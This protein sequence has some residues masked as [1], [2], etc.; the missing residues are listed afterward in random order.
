MICSKCGASLPDD[1]LFCEK[2]GNRVTPV[3]GVQQP[4][5]Q[6]AQGMQQPNMQPMQAPY[7]QPV[8]AQQAP[9]QQQVPPQMNQP[10]G[11]QPYG[12]PPYGQQPYGQQPPRKKTPV[13]LIIILAIVGVLAIGTVIFLVLDKRARDADHAQMEE[14]LASMSS[15]SKE[16]KKNSKKKEETEEETEEEEAEEE[17]EKDTK[18]SKKSKDVNAMTSE[19]AKEYAAFLST[20]DRPGVDDFEWLEE[21]YYDGKDLEA[22]FDQDGATVITNPELVEG[23]WKAC[24]RTKKGMSAEDNDAYRM[25]NVNIHSMDDKVTMTF[26]WWY[27]SFSDPDDG[28]EQEY[29]K[30]TSHCKWNSEYTGFQNDDAGDR[31]EMKKFIDVDGHQYAYGEFMYPSGEE[32]YLILERPGSALDTSMVPAGESRRGGTKAPSSKKLSNEE[33]A[34]LCAKHCGAQFARIDSVNSDGT[35]VVQVYDEVDGHTTTY[36]WYT[37]NTETLAATTEFGF[38]FNLNDDR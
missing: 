37:V 8:Q 2:C 26:D 9:Y 14:E 18:E 23:D 19:E 25:F 5:M 7:Q 32:E 28:Y 3:Q 24:F 10:Y 21:A 29:D 11:Q 15:G 20:T 22:I 35:I 33:I 13:A 31:I 1:S 36:D 34:A 4:N 38:E 6:P 27:Y 30:G 16:G 12:Q 17:E